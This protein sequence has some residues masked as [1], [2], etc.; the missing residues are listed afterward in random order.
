MTIHQTLRKYVF[1]TIYI[2]L[3]FKDQQQLD[4]FLKE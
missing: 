2:C 3:Y 4:I 1:Q